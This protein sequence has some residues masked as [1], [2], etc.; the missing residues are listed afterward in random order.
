MSRVDLLSLTADD[1]ASLTNR[2]TV[3]RAERELESGEVTCQIET[4]ASGDLRFVWS[5]GT[6]C[7][8]PAGKTVREAVCS[9]GVLGISRHVIRSVLAYQKWAASSVV[10]APVETPLDDVATVA[11][12]TESSVASTTPEEHSA[13]P[14]APTSGPQVGASFDPGAFTDEDLVACFKSADVAKARKRFEQGVLVELV[15]GA[16]PVARFLDEACTVRFLVPGDLRYATAD[17]ALAL[18]NLWI[19]LAVWSFRQLP[20]EKLAGLVSLVTQEWP[21]PREVLRELDQLLLELMRGGVS[22][23]ASSFVAK[24]QRMEQSLR[25]AALVWPAELLVDVI[26]QCEMYANHDA[27]FNPQELLH[28]VGELVARVRYIQGGNQRVPQLLVRGSKSDRAID[29]SRGRLIGIGLGVNVGKRHV[30]L[31]SYVQDASSGYVSAVERAFANP[32]PKSTDEPRAIVQ[33]ASTP[34]YRGVSLGSIATSQLLVTS[35]KRRPSGVLTL[36]RT[37][38][39]V[40]CNPQNFQWEQLK[41]PLAADSFAQVRARLELLPPSYLRPRSATENLYVVAIEKATDA[42]FDVARQRLSAQL[43]DRQGEVAVL[44]HP[45]HSRGREGF[46]ELLGELQKHGEQAKFV[47]GYVRQVG[48]MLEVR[49]VCVV[50]ED[51]AVRRGVQ[52]WV[53]RA[54]GSAFAAEHTATEQGGARSAVEQFLDELRDSTS[55]L[56]LSGAMR[57]GCER[58]GELAK[59]GQQLGFVRLV[60]PIEALEKSLARRSTDL[61]WDATEAARVALQLAMLLRISHE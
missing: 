59:M 19:A 40:S 16:K 48:R 32:D 20:A 36:P 44:V 31:S 45:F 39:N 2:G 3:K 23:L 58:F 60:E 12:T 14:A 57:S 15:R 1:L 26:A 47:A 56:L 53:G 55:E 38:G 28:L 54:E 21:V 43:V 61:R 5:E 7:L 42:V 10:A 25:S 50:L 41:P 9:S 11:P 18:Q 17:C 49:P 30:T 52:P 37:A 29:V 4:D 8:F 13:P 35:G 27:Q 51:G 34:I 24:M 33:L 46:D 22:G 6:T